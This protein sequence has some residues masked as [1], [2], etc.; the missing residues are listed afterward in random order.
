MIIAIVLVKAA[1]DRIP[2]AAQAIADLKDVAEVYSCAGNG[3]VDII[4]IVRVSEHE[5]LTEVIAGQLS[6][7]HGVLNTDTR[8]AHQYYSRRD[9]EAAFWLGF[10]DDA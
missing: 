7:S 8:I 6:Q 1:A 3:D 2:E 10:K 5:Q 4:A 9:T